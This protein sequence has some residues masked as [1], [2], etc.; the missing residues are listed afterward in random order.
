MSYGTITWEDAKGGRT[1]TR[2]KDVASA[3]ALQ[4]LAGVLVGYSN[5]IWTN[6][7]VDDPNGAPGTATDAQHQ[8]VKTK[9]TVIMR[10]DNGD[11]A[12][13]SIPAPIESI[14]T[15]DNGQRILAGTNG[16]DITT[17][18]ATATGKSLTFVKARHRSEPGKA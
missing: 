15:W 4:T 8:S 3:A 1:S 12:K 9:C 5:A 10:E 2:I 16:A 6:T 11:I 18:V 13:V 14:Y 17:A 7:R